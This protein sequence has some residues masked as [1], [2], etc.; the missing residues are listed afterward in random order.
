MKAH[1]KNIIGGAVLGLTLLANTGLTWAGYAVNYEVTVT[2]T[3]A[4]GGAR[5]ARFSSDNRQSIGC[6]VD[7]SVSGFYMRCT[8]V[9]RNGA[10]LTCESYDPKLIAVAETM[11]SESLIYFS[12]PA[13]TTTC[14]YIAVDNGS[15]LLR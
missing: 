9:D 5:P 4:T 7:Q 6:A 13:G 8:A 2:A 15:Y 10:I 11:T 12:K 3:N 1:V 14:N